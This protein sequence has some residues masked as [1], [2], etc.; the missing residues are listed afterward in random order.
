MTEDASLPFLQKL[1]MQPARA[2]STID[3]Q[4]ARGIGDTEA[5]S[6]GREN[7]ALSSLER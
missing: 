3:R 2:P 7:V 5:K 6:S 4:T 1:D